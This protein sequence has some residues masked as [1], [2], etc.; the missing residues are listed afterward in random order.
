MIKKAVCPNAS[1][2][3][4]RLDYSSVERLF[5]LFLWSQPARKKSMINVC[6]ACAVLAAVSNCTIIERMS[7]VMYFVVNSTFFAT[8]EGAETLF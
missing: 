8:S 2:A 6:E 4:G 7:T 5:E 1:Y 3:D